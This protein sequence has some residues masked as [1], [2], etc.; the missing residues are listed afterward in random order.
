MTV[1][2]HLETHYQD[3]SRCAREWHGYPD[4][5]EPGQDRLALARP[6]EGQEAPGGRLIPERLKLPLFSFFR[7]RIGSI[8]PPTSDPSDLFFPPSRSAPYNLRPFLLY[9]RSFNLFR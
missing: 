9:P 7:H 2:T 6:A 3:R 5:P 4:H 8:R 1:F